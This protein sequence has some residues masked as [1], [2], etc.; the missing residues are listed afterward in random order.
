VFNGSWNKGGTMGRASIHEGVR[1]MRF[2]SL[3]ERQ[4]RGEITQEEAA[5]L[6]GVHV[7]T[8]QRWADR[9]DEE[10]EAGL[11]DRRLGRPSAKR[12]PPA[13]LE[14]M[15]G[16]YRDKYADFTVKHFHEQ[17]VQ[18]HGYRLGYTVTKLT[19]HAAGLVKRAKQRSAHRKKR[20][21]RPLPGMLLHQD[22]SRHV[23][24]EGLPA[25]DLIATLDDATSAVYSMILVEEEGTAST[26]CALREVIERHGLFCALYSDRGSHYFH[27]RKAGEKV[28]K[29][30]QTQVGR[31]L[32]QLG[33]EHI[34]A[35]S[36]QARGRSE[37]A[38]RTLQDR[39]PKELRLA[40]VSDVAAANRFLREHY[41]AAYNKA[42]AIAPAQEGTAF[43][44][45]RAEAFRE[46]LCVIEERTV[47][48]DNTIAWAGRRLQ[49]PE[50]RLR[51]HF[52]KATVRVHEYP[53][54][55][56]T[57][58]LGPHRLAS[59]TS[60]GVL[61]LAPERI[62]PGS[63]LARVKGGLETA[64]RVAKPPRRP[65]LTRSARAASRAARVGAEKRAPGR[66]KKPI[67]LAEAKAAMS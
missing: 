14:R 13:E 31:A 6:L 34:A 40:G 56:V 63:V 61:D 38:F 50:S 39:L 29:T 65:P 62:E 49:L 20:A 8:F 58:F 41:I 46:I 18:R 5:E 33:I 42:F 32:A 30:Q 55:T 10:G 54:R 11:A 36:P 44:E 37:R 52:V 21:R 24:I 7:R 27:T 9:Y 67:K 12:S 57:V 26:F 17:L 47:G 1:Q 64:E 4:E 25:M 53:D 22:G 19:L 45:D 60:A 3:L 28:S 35:Y 43:V 15:L 59:Y 2:S 66:T 51:P 48:N 16:L 23:W